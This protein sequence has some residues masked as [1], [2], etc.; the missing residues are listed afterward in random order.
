[1]ELLPRL[2]TLISLPSFI[3]SLALHFSHLEQPCPAVVTASF[4]SID[5]LRSLF[6]SSDIF[7]LSGSFQELK[8]WKCLQISRL[9]RL[10]VWLQV[11][12]MGSVRW[13]QKFFVMLHRKV[14]TLVSVNDLWPLIQGTGRLLGKGNWESHPQIIPS[15][16]VALMQQLCLSSATLVQSVPLSWTKAARHTASCHVHWSKIQCCM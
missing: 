7:A 2:S 16:S 12:N 5:V 1:M 9:T 3:H 10:T 13:R 14:S 6:K 15:A 4:S 8:T 11:H